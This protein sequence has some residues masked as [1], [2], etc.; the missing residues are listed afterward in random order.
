M[1]KLSVVIITKNEEKNIG[2]AIKSALF[3]DEVIVL[4]SGSK[5]KT[6]CISKEMGAK[7]FFQEWLGYGSQKNKA[8]E[9]AKNNWVFVLDADER[10]TPE[11]QN[12]ILDILKSPRLSGYC[13]PRLNNFFG[14]YI[15]TCGLYPDYSIRLFD[16][17]KGK[18]SEVSVHESVQ[19]DSTVAKLKNHMIH[20]AYDNVDEFKDKQKKYANLSCKKKNVFKALISPVWTFVNLYFFKFGFLEGWRG[21]IIAKIYAQYTFWKYI[22]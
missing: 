6:L 8:I 17:N 5:D 9:L 11:L 4:D 12:E 2:D 13:V 14:Q 15:K 18:F 20:L 16:K 7:V 19:I 3:A 22:D 1:N 10:I 21:L